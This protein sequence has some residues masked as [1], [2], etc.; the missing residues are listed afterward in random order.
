MFQE[1]SMFNGIDSKEKLTILS[2]SYTVT[3]TSFSQYDSIDFDSNMFDF[4]SE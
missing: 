4:S 2:S 3:K 1:I